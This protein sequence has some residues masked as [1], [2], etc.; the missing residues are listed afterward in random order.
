LFK[1]KKKNLKGNLSGSLE[2][3]YTSEVNGASFVENFSARAILALT[4]PTKEI[5]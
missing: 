2:N 1:K 5:L 3:F 4:A